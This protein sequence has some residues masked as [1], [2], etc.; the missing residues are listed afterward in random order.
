LEHTVSHYVISLE[1][2]LGGKWDLGGKGTGG[3]GLGW[4]GDLGGRGDMGGKGISGRGPGGKGTGTWVRIV[5]K[6]SVPDHTDRVVVNKLSN[7]RS[8][9]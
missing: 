7:E 8:Q 5:Q 2:E 4:K 1:G 3:R 6:S 9:Q